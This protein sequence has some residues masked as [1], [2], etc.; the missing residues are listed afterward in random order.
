MTV[1]LGGSYLLG[2]PA[3]WRLR[4]MGSLSAKA[5]CGQ[6]S[7]LFREGRSVFVLLSDWMRP[8]HVMKDFPPFP[9]VKNDFSNYE[10]F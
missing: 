3:G 9:Y 2:R 6:N 1:R 7:F 10:L 4:K 5:I 8:T